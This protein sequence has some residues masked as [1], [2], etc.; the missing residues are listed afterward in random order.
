MARRLEPGVRTPGPRGGQ[1][2]RHE[3]Q[4]A[5]EAPHP[6]GEHVAGPEAHPGGSHAPVEHGEGQEKEQHQEVVEAYHG[7]PEE[8]HHELGEGVV[9]GQ[10]EPLA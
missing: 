6:H 9:G 1:N 5:D 4:D 7:R 3:G 10:E 2:G 8:G